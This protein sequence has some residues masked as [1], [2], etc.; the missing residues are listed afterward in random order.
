MTTRPVAQQDNLC[1]H[2]IFKHYNGCL[3]LLDIRILNILVERAI[4]RPK[5]FFGISPRKILK[6]L[7]M[8][9]TREN[10]GKV[11]TALNVLE[12]EGLVYTMK[13]SPRKYFPSTKAVEAHGIAAGSQTTMER[14]L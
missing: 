5:M 7:N 10:V 12:R 9:P 13:A 11:R 1:D 8:R 14:W 2:P 6:F 4:L 3:E